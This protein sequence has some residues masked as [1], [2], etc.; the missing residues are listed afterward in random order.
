MI[1]GTNDRLQN[2]NKLQYVYKSLQNT[3]DHMKVLA[4]KGN[5]F[6]LEGFKY[7]FLTDHT[8]RVT[9]NTNFTPA[10][11]VA[12]ITRDQVYEL[13]CAAP[14]EKISLFSPIKMIEALAKKNEDLDAALK[15]SGEL[16]D[17]LMT[18]QKEL[19]QAKLDLAN[20]TKTLGETITELTNKYK[21][22]KLKYN[23]EIVAAKGRD[24][25]MQHRMGKL[26][27][28]FFS[29]TRDGKHKRRTDGMGWWHLASW[30]PFAGI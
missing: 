27:A 25:N 14:N 18:T 9:F 12:Q 17:S 15:R 8:G 1:N 19:N 21:R 11:C 22:Y 10:S 16:D 6:D 3:K 5:N 28:F 2:L 7:E 29:T 20:T 4:I 24:L 13:A 26:M 23:T 30:L